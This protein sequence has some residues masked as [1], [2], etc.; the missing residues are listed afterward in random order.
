MFF[1]QYKHE[2]EIAVVRFWVAYSERPAAGRGD[3]G[4]ARGGRAALEAM[5]RHLGDR[6]YFVGER[7]TIADIAL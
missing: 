5:E 7:Y 4:Q 1:E 3:R 6:E 2:P